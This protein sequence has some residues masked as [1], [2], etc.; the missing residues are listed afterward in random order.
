MISFT[1]SKVTKMIWNGDRHRSES[2]ESVGDISLE[3]YEKIHKLFN[4]E[5][6]ENFHIETQSPLFTNTVWHDEERGWFEAVQTIDENTYILS[7]VIYG[8]FIQA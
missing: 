6:V 2:P 1:I 3:V 7:F 5:E 8:Y 4:D